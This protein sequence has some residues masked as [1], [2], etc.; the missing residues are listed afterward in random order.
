MT[1]G[2]VEAQYMIATSCKTSD[3]D[4]KC[5]HDLLGG[6]TFGGVAIIYLEALGLI[7]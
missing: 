1:R 3:R 5:R 2:E 6:H 7:A 4:D